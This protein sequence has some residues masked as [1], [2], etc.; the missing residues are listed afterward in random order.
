MTRCLF[1]SLFA[2]GTCSA[3]AQPK[4]APAPVDPG[5]TF[6]PTELR[7]DLALMRT[8]L[9]ES[10]PGLYRYTPKERFAVLFDSISRSFTRPMTQQ[11]FY[12]A[13]TPIVA[14]IKDGH[15]KYMPRV[16]P[17]WQYYYQL[18]QLF[19]LSLHITGPKAHLLRNLAGAGDIPLGAEITAINGQPVAGLIGQLLPTVYFADG[20]SQAIKYQSL[21]KFFPFYYGTYLGAA[22]VYTIAYRLPGQTRELSAQVPAI[23]LATLEKAEKESQPP[24]QLPIR[25][26]YPEAG[27]ALLRIDH[28]NIYKK[29][30]D[31]KK[32]FRE[33]FWQLHARNIRHLII[34]L[35]GNEGGVDKWGALLYS[36]LSDKPF[37]Y[38]DRLEVARKQPFSFQEHIAWAPKIFPLYRR[39]LSKNE[40]GRYT[41]RFKKTLK[42]QKPQPR[43]FQ[44]EVYVL[45]DGYSFSVTAEFAAIAHHHRRA[46]FVGRETGGA[47]Y[48]NNSGF[49]V[50]SVLPHT[51]IEIA[52]PQ[53]AYYMAVSGY[54]HADRGVL[55]DY[56][57]VPGISDLLQHRDAELDFTLD[58]IQ[59]KK[60]AARR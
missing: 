39:L 28:F 20:N 33:M 22:A 21:S 36:Y 41:F 55:P 57:V 34:D 10:H 32:T 42:T 3:L 6:S 30:M 16:R 17:H 8:I 47:Y 5:K 26:T 2:L 54:P 23:T 9:E 45:T 43:P 49:F 60:S 15:L 1:S 18:D 38:Y 14:A 51:G 40:E 19:P 58:L 31:V 11:E 29:E 48:G 25:L 35:R 37:R 50:V 46:T 24:R 52:T 12:V 56:E 27:T 59:K 53:W 7:A 13:A 44:G 4:P